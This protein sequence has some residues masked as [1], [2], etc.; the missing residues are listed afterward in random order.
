M[1]KQLNVRLPEHTINQIQDLADSMDESQAHVIILAVDRLF[2]SS[3]IPP[4][5]DTATD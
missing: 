1:R 3:T 5:E 2:V 4:P